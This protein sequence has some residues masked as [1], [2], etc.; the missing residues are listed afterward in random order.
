MAINVIGGG[1]HNMSGAPLTECMLILPKSDPYE[2]VTAAS[3]AFMRLTDLVSQR[4]GSSALASGL[5][6]G[7]TPNLHSIEKTCEILVAAIAGEQ[8]VI[9]F[10]AAA[11]TLAVPAETEQ[12]TTTYFVDGVTL[13]GR[14][15]AQKYLLLKDAYPLGYLEDPFADHDLS[16]WRTLAE[17]YL[18]DVG[19]LGIVA[20]DLTA[21]DTHRLSELNGTGAS[22]PAHSV[23]AKVDQCG[24]VSR[25]LRFV[26]EAQLLGLNIVVSQRSQETDQ[27]FL[28]DLSVGLGAQMMKS[29]CITR[30]R[31]VKYNRLLRIGEELSSGR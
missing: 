12:G 8:M 21:T 10:D 22:F 17:D 7:L 18:P 20:D 27:S 26:Q 1:G 2:M 4:F 6:G 5:E 30:E 28:V 11:N 13:R 15:L 24:T 14:D 19:Q 31:I 3:S 23:M 16:S 29:G 25:L 9:G